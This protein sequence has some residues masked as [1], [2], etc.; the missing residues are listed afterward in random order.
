MNPL[1]SFRAWWRM[2]QP[3][4]FTTN[5]A[6][7]D[8]Y[9]SLCFDASYR[10]GLLQSDPSVFW[11]LDEAER[12]S[13]YTVSLCVGRRWVHLSILGAIRPEP[14]PDTRMN[15]TRRM[16][17]VVYRVAIACLLVMA[18][19][20]AVFVAKCVLWW[21]RSH[22]LHLVAA[23]TIGQAAVV[24]CLFYVR[25]CVRQVRASLHQSRVNP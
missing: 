19:V 22:S 2:R 4:A 23:G 12:R 9:A 25:W 16:D 11:L 15:R 6:A 21:Q 17:R 7:K 1:K 13:K 20:Q 18:V 10:P 3:L 8:G 24:L 14:L 5:R